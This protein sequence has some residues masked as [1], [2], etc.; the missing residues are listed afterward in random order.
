MILNAVDLH[1]HAGIGVARRRHHSRLRHAVRHRR[2]VRHRPRC[3]GRR[4]RH[5]A[6]RKQ[7]QRRVCG[8]GPRH[9]HRVDLR[10]LPILRCHD[11]PYDVARPHRQPNDAVLINHTVELHLKR[12]SRSRRRCHHRLRH[13][14]PHRRRVRRSPRRESRRQRH[15]AQRQRTQARVGRPGPRHRHRIR[16]SCPPILRR[17]DHRYDVARP[18]H[19]SHDAVLVNHTVQ[20][21]LIRRFRSSRRRHRRFRHSMPRRRR[22]RS[23]PRRKR[24]RQRHP[25]QR[26]HTQASVRRSC[27]WHTVGQDFVALITAVGPVGRPKHSAVGPDALQ[28]RGIGCRKLLRGVACARGQVIC[29]EVARQAIRNPHGRAVRPKAFGVHLGRVQGNVLVAVPSPALQFVRVQRLVLRVRHPYRRAMQ[30][31][32][33]HTVVPRRTQRVNVVVAIS[34]LAGYVIRDDL[35]EFVIGDPYGRPVGRAAARPIVLV[36]VELDVAVLIAGRD[37]TC[38]RVRE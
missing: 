15:P 18:H 38:Q 10:R 24:R 37:V 26:E 4:Q 28:V 11:H 19:Q 32:V 34:G 9:R 29:E 27:C 20:L 13:R 16:L 12:R 36:E 33:S 31:D 1:L 35:V 8:A 17:H 22:V 23:S 6:Q 14:M 30:R 5:S 21:H 3:E 2:R 7:A 25:A